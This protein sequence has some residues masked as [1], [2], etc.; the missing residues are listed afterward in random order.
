M[1]KKIIRKTLKHAQN[2]PRWAKIVSIS[3]LLLVFLQPVT[4]SQV[5]D[6]EQKIVRQQLDERQRL[7]AVISPSLETQDFPAQLPLDGLKDFFGNQEL[8]SGNAVVVNYTL[9]QNLQIKAK[10]LLESYKP[11][12]GALFMMDAI[13]GR[14]LAMTSFERDAEKP[15]NWAKRARA[16]AAS[17]FKIIT[18]TAAI[19]RKGVTAFRTI[20]FNGGNYTLYKKNVLSEK[21]NRWT[22][23]VTLKDAF[24]KSLNTAFGRLSL[25]ELTPKDMEEYAGRFFF[26][27]KIPADFDVE[28]S[29][30]RI[31]AEKGFEFT[32]VA[33]GYNKFNLMSPVHGAMIAASVINGG[34][35]IIPYVVDELKTPLGQS[36][37]QGK[38]LDNGFVMTSESANTVRTLMEETIHSGTSRKTFRNLVNHKNFKEIEMGGKTGHFTGDDPK[39]RVDW[40][41]G[42][43]SD[44]NH[45]IAIAALTINKKFWT[46]KSSYLGQ[47]LFRSYF[48]KLNGHDDLERVPASRRRHARR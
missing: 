12:Y 48:N 1:P 8:P 7:S 14:V 11:D 28:K 35:M 9:D 16:P 37:Y 30:A 39:G 33:S 38:P 24:A 46:V 17:V 5:E 29:T 6:N 42:Y 13:T 34:K 10:K 19:D 23:S 43:A 3:F 4:Q 40:F 26:N 45:K 22:R 25:E 27:Q 32:E 18:A 15:G 36:I 44:E 41:V 21:N 47:T 31:P 20:R 2:M